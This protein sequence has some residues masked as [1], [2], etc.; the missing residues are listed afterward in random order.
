MNGSFPLAW[1]S[2][3][4]PSRGHSFFASHASDPSGIRPSAT[5]RSKTVGVDTSPGKRKNTEG[6]MP[7]VS[8]ARSVSSTSSVRSVPGSSRK[9]ERRGSEGL[10]R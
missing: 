5:I 3:M 8:I 9:F 6:V 2:T 10:D 4:L 7:A 1:T